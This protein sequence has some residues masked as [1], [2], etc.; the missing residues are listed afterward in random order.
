[1]AH[2]TFFIHDIRQTLMFC[3]I[4]CIW[5]GASNRSIWEVQYEIKSVW[6]GFGFRPSFYLFFWKAWFD[7]AEHF[8][9]DRFH[10]F[11]L[12]VFLFLIFETSRWFWKLL[13]R[14]YRLLLLRSPTKRPVFHFF[15]KIFDGSRL[16]YVVLRGRFEPR[17]RDFGV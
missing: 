11:S 7:F 2:E 9:A 3:I 6:N 13:D 1:M 17:N 10:P 12:F 15:W 5:E 4:E 8:L 14:F 16:I